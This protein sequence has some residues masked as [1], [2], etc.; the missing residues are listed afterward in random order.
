MKSYK[1][2]LLGAVIAIV[3]FC[4][5][6]FYDTDTFS[7]ATLQYFGSD[8]DVSL[9]WDNS[10][11]ELD[12]T[13]ATGSFHFTASAVADGKYGL[14]VGSTIAG[15]TKS[16]GSAAYFH[17]TLTGN[18]DAPTYNIG[19]WLDI[20]GGTPTASVLAAADFGIYVSSAGN[21]GSAG[22]VVGLQIQLIIDDANGPSSLYMMRFNSLLAGSGGVAPSHWFQAANKESIAYEANTAHATSATDKIGAIKIS[23]VGLGDCYF[24]IYSHA[25][26]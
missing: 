7:D 1:N 22:H 23:V 26:E 13:T 8:R 17:T 24:Y 4:S 10:N 21:L 9:Q 12:F 3:L 18:I 5:F 11:N 2:I 15:D 16:E 6:G 14:E 20:T 19:S 25:G